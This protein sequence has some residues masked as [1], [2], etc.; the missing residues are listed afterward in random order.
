MFYF[1]FCSASTQKVHNYCCVYVLNGVKAVV[2][3]YCLMDLQRVLE[4]FFFILY[5]IHS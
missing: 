1:S 5:S 2:V 3:L 4:D